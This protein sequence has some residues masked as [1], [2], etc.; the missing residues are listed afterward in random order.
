MEVL[1]ETEAVLVGWPAVGVDFVLLGERVQKAVAGHSSCGVCRLFFTA[2]RLAVLSALCSLGPILF[3]AVLDHLDALIAR[4]KERSEGVR[5]HSSLHLNPIEQRH[6][7]LLYTRDFAVWYNELL[8]V[9]AEALQ[10]LDKA[11]IALEHVEPAR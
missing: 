11:E 4:G 9:A 8:V 5:S 3:G 7:L 2:R 6:F 10:T 1:V